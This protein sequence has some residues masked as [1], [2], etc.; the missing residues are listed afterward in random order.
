MTTDRGMNLVK[1][2]E[3]QGIAAEVIGKTTQGNDRILVN[4]EER[5]F[6]EPARED[7]LYKVLA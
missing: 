2:L 1:K 6:L 4:E 3:Q 5:R 7:E